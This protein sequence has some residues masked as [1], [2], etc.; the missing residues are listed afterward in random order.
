MT[1]PETKS[2]YYDLF[3]YFH[4]NYGLVLTDTEIQDIIWFIKK[5][6]ELEGE[7]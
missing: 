6:L 7:I 5:Y 3:E 2:C 4:K 1:E